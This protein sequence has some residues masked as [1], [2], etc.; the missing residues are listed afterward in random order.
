AFMGDL[1]LFSDRSPSLPLIGN[2]AGTP[3]I[4]RGRPAKGILKAAPQPAMIVP[5]SRLPQTRGNRVNRMRGILRN[6]R[7]LTPADR[8]EGAPR[9]S[10]AVSHVAGAVVIGLVGVE[11]RGRVRGLAVPGFVESPAGEECRN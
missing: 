9:A 3:E 10:S 5:S 2:Y 8:G 11:H 7:R 1:M 6:P 4:L